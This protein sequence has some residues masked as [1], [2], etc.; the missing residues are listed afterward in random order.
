MLHQSHRCNPQHFHNLPQP[1]WPN[2]NVAHHL[3]LL[4]VPRIADH[5]PLAE[6]YVLPRPPLVE[7][8]QGPQLPLVPG[9]Y[10][11]LKIR[12]LVVLLHIG[13]VALSQILDVQLLVL[14]IQFVIVLCQILKV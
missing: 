14:H 3:G 1:R 5:R 4:G 2:S 13:F 6:W 9:R 10:A 12:V 11:H 8:V 7:L